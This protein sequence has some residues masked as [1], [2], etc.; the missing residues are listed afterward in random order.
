[1]TSMSVEE[2]PSDVVALRSKTNPFQ[3]VPHDKKAVEVKE[4]L[5]QRKI[6][7][8]VDGKRSEF[9]SRDKLQACR[10][11]SHTFVMSQRAVW[12]HPFRPFSCQLQQSLIS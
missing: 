1:M 11:E 7:A 3:D 6:H 2:G 10:F 12:L 8:D 4:G 9:L 5:L